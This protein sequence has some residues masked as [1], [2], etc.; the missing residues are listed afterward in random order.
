MLYV[1]KDYA[2][3]FFINL[4]CGYSSFEKLCNDGHI[5]KLN[6]DY[7]NWELDNNVLEKID[8]ET[9]NLWL[10]MRCPY[11]RICSFYKD[12]FIN[13]FQPNNTIYRNQL[14]QLDMYKLVDKTKIEN[15][16]FT[17]S[18]FI[19]KVKNGYTD[20][21]IEPQSNILKHNV[22]NEKIN[23]IKFENR[24]FNDICERIIGIE[25]PKVNVTNSSSNILND[26][27]REYIFNMY[28]K[29][30]ELYNSVF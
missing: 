20:K 8:K 27:E 3:V 16:E 5:Y 28:K 25:L 10:I 18:E 6:I 4:K 24:N 29:D 9:V 17:V 19:D 21:H 7:N 26:T 15:L 2:N 22:F 14:C 30:F 11:A 1:T 23:I 13:C 12:K